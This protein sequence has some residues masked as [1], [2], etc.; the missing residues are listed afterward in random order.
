MQMKEHVNQSSG[1]PCLDEKSVP[2]IV[3]Q[4][5]RQ[6]LLPRATQAMARELSTLSHIVDYLLLGRA[7]EAIDTATQRLKALELALQGQPWTTA[8]KVELIQASEP[9]FATRPEI[10]MAMKEAKEDQRAKASSY[11]YV[12]GEGKGKSKGKSKEKDKGKGKEK[13]KGGGNQEGKR[14]S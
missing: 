4:Y 13:S 6:F 12:P 5:C 3:L 7:A 10:Q 2:P 8:S 1:V 9:S 11:S 14:P